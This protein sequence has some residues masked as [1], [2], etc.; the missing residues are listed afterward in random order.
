MVDRTK[1]PTTDGADRAHAALEVSLASIP[2]LGPEGYRITLSHGTITH[3][4]P[5]PQI[6]CA[7]QT[8][9]I[10]QHLDGRDACN[11]QWVP[12]FRKSFLD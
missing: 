5:L 4:G 7:A 11:D 9:L 3:Y 2:V 1:V 12:E 6:C 10:W 8:Y